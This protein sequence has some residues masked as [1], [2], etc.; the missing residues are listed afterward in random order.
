MEKFVNDSF[1]HNLQMAQW[2]RFSR[3]VLPNFV[4]LSNDKNIES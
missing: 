2:D 3:N 4:Y 1:Y